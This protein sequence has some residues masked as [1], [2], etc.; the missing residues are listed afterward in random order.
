MIHFFFLIFFFALFES[1]YH[2]SVIVHRFALFISLRIA[3]VLVITFGPGSPN[4]L[5]I[6]NLAFSWG[7]HLC[8]DSRLGIFRFESSY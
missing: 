7:A 1:K 4:S 8:F 6:L 5:L 2:Y 3:E